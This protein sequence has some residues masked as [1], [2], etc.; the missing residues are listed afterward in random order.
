MRLKPTKNMKNI[1]FARNKEKLIEP[2]Y[3]QEEKED[4][5]DDRKEYP[6][7]QH[8]RENFSAESFGYY[9]VQSW[10]TKTQT[11]IREADELLK[12][13]LSIRKKIDNFSKD[14]NMMMDFRESLTSKNPQY[15]ILF[16]HLK[17][18][19]DDWQ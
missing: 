1:V 12:K 16:D 5:D 19:K 18:L 7:E 4:I 11:D 2:L 13:Y 14:Y 8:V 9:D 3:E 10:L 17:A 15:M 6:V